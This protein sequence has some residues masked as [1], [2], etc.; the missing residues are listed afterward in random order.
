MKTIGR[1]FVYMLGCA[2]A[3]SYASPSWAYSAAPRAS[4]AVHAWQH[5]I[6]GKVTDPT[7]VPLEGASITV[8]GQPG[9]SVSDVLGNFSLTAADG[10]V[11]VITFVGYATQEL[12]VAGNA[13]VNAVLQPSG[14][15]LEEVVVT[16]LGIEKEKRRIGYAV[17]EVKGEALQKA[18]SPNVLESL[19]GKVSGLVITNNGGD[20]FSDPGIYLRGNRPLYV[21]DGVPMDT[22]MWNISS[23]D[24]ESVSV[25]KSA[26]ASALYG[27]RG[28]NGAIQITM[29]SGR[30]AVDGTSVTLNSSTTFQGGF[31]RIPKAQNQYGPG[32]AGR[33]AFGTGAAGGG[34]I[35]DFDYS[36]WGPKFD[37]RL[38]PQ[39]DSPID[40]QTGQRIPTEWVARTDDNLGNFMETGLVTST[41]VSV[42]SQGKHGHFIIS[43]TY[44][45]SKASQPGSKLDVNVTR[46][47][48]TLKLSDR[49]SVEGALQYDYQYS[50]NRLR[51]VYG[52]TSII[53]NLAIWGGA[54]FDVRDFKNY[55]VPGRENVQQYFVENWRFNNPYALANAWQQPYEKNDII[56]NLKVNFKISDKVNAFVRSTLNTYSL[57]DEDRIAV[58]IYNYDVTDRG[59]RYRYNHN[60]MMESNTDLLLN[61]NNNFYNGDFSVDATLG[62]NQRYYQSEAY[63]AFT[64]QL[65]VPGVFKLSNSV[66]QTTP[67]SSRYRKGV[68]SAYASLDLAYKNWFYLGFTG[69]V[70]NSSTLPAGNSAFFYPSASFS[71]VLTDIFKLPAAISFLKLRA[72]YAKVGGDLGIY[73]AVN[74][75][76]TGSRYR[77]LPL[78]TYP[79]VLDNP[80]ISP[81]F[82][83]AYEYGMEARFFNSRLGFDFSY[84][85][86]NYGPQIFTQRF[87]ETSGYTGIR[88]NGRT[89]Q[90][91]GADFSIN[92][93]PVR[94]ANF[95]WSTIINA[96]LGR[97]YLTSL[98]PLPDGTPQEQEGRTKIGG[99]LGDYWYNEW[100]RSPDGQLVIQAN[101]LPR[102]T[103]V[104]RLIGNTQPDFTIG[105]GNTFTYKAFT[106]NFLFDARF[107]GAT[108]DAYERDLWRSGSHPNAV[109]PERELSNIAYA[110]GTD[111][112]TMQIPGV[113]VV[114]GEI[115]YDPEGKVL[116]D[117]RVFEP[118]DYKVDYQNWA[119]GYMGAWESNV[120]EKTFAKLREVTLTYNLPVSLLKTRWFK[121][122]SVSFVGRNLLYWTKDKTFGDLDTYTMSTGD[123]QLQHPAQRTYGFNLN[124]NF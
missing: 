85:E 94:S 33:Y 42:Q 57:T 1:T 47:H 48:G 46:L 13:A 38:I 110:D 21:V 22:D 14:T 60:K 124:L 20:F 52:P 9:G 55:W 15:G 64:T 62:G 31:I 28:I 123:T 23:D 51:A 116:T 95:N 109:H 12:T 61:Y 37:G 25:L 54:H 74:T 40:P 36:I 86:N 49:V 56:G 76:S 58:S 84:Y 24:I 79:S 82:N 17:Q 65:V 5:Q 19:T 43:N 71:T 108:F 98:P 67:T 50:N 80:G 39:Y 3:I 104:Q 35:N 111:A 66:D 91:R 73:E 8:K 72:S 100:E 89:T 63:N 10:D 101:G 92:A 59:G 96:D 107:G 112:K 11:L 77:N 4:T 27:S 6:K 114:S 115:T 117:T 102:R 70:D 2:S 83:T 93:V 99:R 81:S 30:S 7:G 34:G 122:A 121:G 106:L 118:S 18:I 41:N 105:F 88:L 78:A 90:R 113:K 97:D 68:Y 45:Y 26:A 32:N 53:Y 16:A 87:S 75:Y 120:I 119:I 103:D 29:K 69:R 44:K